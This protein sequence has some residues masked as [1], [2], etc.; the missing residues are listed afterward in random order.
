M[1]SEPTTDK[2]SQ[3]FDDNFVAAVD[4]CLDELSQ[5][6]SSACSYELFYDQLVT[7]FRSVT[8]ATSVAV[9]IPG[10]NGAHVPAVVSSNNESSNMARLAGADFEKLKNSKQAACLQEEPSVILAAE[11]ESGRDQDLILL[12][13]FDSP[14]NEKLRSFFLDLLDAFADIAES[15]ENHQSASD[16]NTRFA[17]IDAFVQLIKNAN[18]TLDLEET[19]FQIVNDTRAFLEADRV[20]LFSTISRPK[21]IA[22]SSVN[23]VN[24]R[25]RDY[26][27]A[28]KLV[29]RATECN[30][31]SEGPQHV[32]VLRRPDDQREIGV[33]LTEFSEPLDQIRVVE[34][35]N[36]IVPP[37]QSSFNNALAHSRLPFRKS[38]GAIQWV[39]DRLSAT[40][41]TALFVLLAV[42]ATF[43][44]Q[45]DFNIDVK[46][47]LRPVIERHLFA[48]TDAFVE[49]VQV[50][51]G[52][53]VKESQPVL[54]LRSDE[55]DLKIA[56]LQNELSGIRKQLEANRLLRSQARQEKRESGYTSQLTAAIEKNNLQIANINQQLDWYLNKQQELEIQ[57]PY[58]GMVITRDLRTKLLQRPVSRGSQLLTISRTDGDWQVILEIDDRDLGYLNQAN[59]AQNIEELKIQFRLE[60]NLENTFA[61]TITSTDEH[62]TISKDR[63]FVRAFVPVDKDA[64]GELRVG[65][66][67]LGKVHCGK[68][69][70]FFIWTRDVR[71]FIRT[72][73][74]WF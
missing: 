3:P 52:D 61:G 32:T 65:Q 26:Q 5:L 8:E 11:I 39:T 44:I 50:K 59:E 56:E 60:S 15:F 16:Q 58:H 20:W 14:T 46:G 38:L 49:T 45:T 66:A 23:S 31:T 48:P 36:Q 22:C 62:N 24:K 40:V 28:L 37:I 69:S 7:K 57:S 19:G 71:D 74:F 53:I 41:G 18:A 9:L 51:Y 30:I 27:E 64:L 54:G 12:A 17:K 43:F 73:Y 70:L 4:V 1:S 35:L 34:R 6:A 10:P 68:K 29:R 21:L 42:A 63:S 67:V 2:S 47:E 55:Y 25:T 72:N 13:Q 33:L